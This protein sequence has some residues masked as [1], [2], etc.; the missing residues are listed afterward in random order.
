MKPIVIFR[1]LLV[2]LLLM[3]AGSVH[4]VTADEPFVGINEQLGTKIP[5]D[6]SFTD[7]SGKAVRLGDLITGP[8]IVLPVYYNCTNVCYNLQW[9]LAQVLPRI[10][11]RPGENYRVLSVS[12]DEN[13]L[14]QLAAKFKRVYLTS[15]HVPFPE[16][17]WRFLTGD[18]DSIR[19]F[20]AA[21]GYGFQR[22]RRDFLHPS[23]SFIV[24]ADGTIVRYLYGTTFLP[25]DLS[26]ALIEARD[27]TSGTT[28]RK[29]VDYCFTFD[30]ERKTYAFN[31]LRIS[32]T[33]VII[34]TGSFLVF[35][36]MTGRKRK[37]PAQRN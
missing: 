29:I 11:N 9:G 27:G 10:K 1:M 34:C 23:T 22:K 30:P 31:L 6:I 16:D 24:T 14:P 12:F 19:K 7:E 33:I 25:K 32:A 5:L 4:A 20:T 26:L 13:D 18:A 36:I 2:L 35:L 28:I 3:A 15:M 21:A 17:A 37:K 8:T